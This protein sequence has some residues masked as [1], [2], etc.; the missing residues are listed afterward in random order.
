M[1]ILI[2]FLIIYMN[3]KYYSTR[4]NEIS[5]GLERV[6]LEGLARD[7]G[8]Y[9]PETIPVLTEYE[10]ESLQNLEFNQILELI[11]SKYTDINLS[12]SIDTKF[13]F[14]PQLIEYS[15]H[16]YLLDLNTGPTSAFKDYGA[17]TLAIV[18]NEYLNS[19]DRS[20]NSLDSKECQLIVNKP[21]G[22]K[23]NETPLNESKLI[24][25]A[26]S[27]DTGSA[28]ANAFQDTSTA[29]KVNVMVFYPKGRV[30]DDQRRLMTTIEGNIICVEVDGNFDDC[31]RIVKDAMSDESI[32]YRLGSANS[33]NWL[34]LIGQTAY[35]FYA[36]SRLDIKDQ[37]KGVAFSVPSGNLGNITA[38]YISKLMGLNII[39][40]IASHNSN[41]LFQYFVLD[42]ILKDQKN[43]IRTISSAMDVAKPSN[44]ERLIV[45]FGGSFDKKG[46][47]TKLPDIDGMQEVFYAQGFSD[48]ETKQM[49]KQFYESNSIM[50]DPHTAVGLLGVNDAIEKTGAEHPELINH[51]II[52][53]STADPSKFPI[54]SYEVYNT[55]PIPTEPIIR[56]RT[57][58]ETILKYYPNIIKDYLLT[59]K[60]NLMNI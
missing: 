45:L 20:N 32:K 36:F 23:M 28:V 41:D 42:G 3:I 55:Y 4:G 9:L 38:G 44:L 56:A 60:I 17:N 53:L 39:K 13:N 51:A 1:L 22:E 40:L 18:M 26:T 48:I 15:P 50:I 54:E 59:G 21:S 30:S 19:I 57:K 31:Q 49:M 37:L 14:K 34:R 6:V 16:R 12:K 47:I 5:I 7:G 8:L 52:T 27:G 33:I 58:G 43:S 2:M 24:L 35:Y 46:N 25:V 29:A 11:L 10:L